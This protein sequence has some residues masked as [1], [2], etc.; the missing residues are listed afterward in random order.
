MRL[1]VKTYGPY[2]YR[3]GNR[4]RRFVIHLYDDGTRRTQ[5]NAR[6]LL[7][8]HLGR[9]LTEDEDADHIDGNPL[10][11]DLSNLRPLSSFEN[12]SRAHE[13]APLYEFSCLMCGNSA[14]T[15]LRDYRRN[16]EVLGKAGPFCSK[17]CS[18]TWSTTV[19]R[20]NQGNSCKPHKTHCKYGHLK[21]GLIRKADGSV[22]KNCNECNRLR[23]QLRRK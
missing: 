20:A 15:L 10:N 22:Y 16:Q 19:D 7:E 11:D 17:S 6:Y 9:L 18:G 14:V 21:T 8:Q 13:P 2:I 1:L 5:S 3:S 12:R 23:A 4:L